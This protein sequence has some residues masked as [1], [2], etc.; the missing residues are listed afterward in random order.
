MKLADEY[1]KEFH[2]K[3]STDLDTSLIFSG[4]FSAV[5]SAFIIQIEP[6]LASGNPPTIIV[7]VQCMLYA[8]LFVTLL[9]AL[10][11]VL[12]KQWV[13]YYQAAG[14]R[15]TIKERGLE[16]QR[17]LD[18]LIKWK[19]DA[20]LQTFPLLLQLGLLLFASSISLYLWT[21]HHSVAI[22]FMTMTA[23]GCGLYLFFLV[24][25]T[26]Y[27]DCPFQTPLRPFVIQV[28][29]STQ[30][31]LWTLRA[32]TR[33]S[34]QT[35][36][37]LFMK[38]FRFKL[39]PATRKILGPLVRFSSSGIHLL[40]HL[41]SH[42]L[43]L[44]HTEESTNP[45]AYHLFNPPAPEVPAV[46]WV[47]KTSTDPFMIHIAA[48]IGVDLQWPRSM[49]FESTE[50]VM[51]RLA[52]TLA[53]C[54]QL[55]IAYPAKVR[56]GMSDVAITCGKLYGSLRLVMRATNLPTRILRNFAVEVDNGTEELQSVLH[57]LSDMPQ[58]T[59][60][61]ETFPVTTRNTRTL[62]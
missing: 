60:Q 47:L 40:S 33:K 54:L 6:Q 15:G 18:G 11:A 30:T 27:H 12:G 21:V 59:R 56:E 51:N 55:R 9:A 14:S 31:I 38:M 37:C 17:K 5:G 23:L 28:L 35:F 10:L 53:S 46:L 50:T 62:S 24:S 26:V 19:F 52:D 3:Y 43:P 13:M 34:L 25:A 20:V 7:V 29:Q 39:Q 42:I 36:S 2:Q 58:L 49:D 22:V 44:S 61:W 32:G 1:D 16:R 41:P 57:I 8:S 45:S 48:E 4:L